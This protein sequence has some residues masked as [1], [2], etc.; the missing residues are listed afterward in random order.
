MI[1]E[2][3][4]T[5]LV[6]RQLNNFWDDVDKSIIVAAVTTYNHEPKCCRQLLGVRIIAI[7]D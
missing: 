6:L 3:K 1:E 4:I 5:N 7:S 2:D